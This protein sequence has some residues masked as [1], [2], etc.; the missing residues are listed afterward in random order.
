M[1]D[2]EELQ[3]SL[4]PPPPLSSPSS[5]DASA[6]SYPGGPVSLGWPVP[7]RSSG[8]TVDPLE[9]VELQMG[10]FVLKYFMPLNFH[11]IL[12]ESQ[13][14]Q[15]IVNINRATVLPLAN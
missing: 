5:S 1:A 8:R 3:V 14:H 7:S 2:A 13:L 10:D 6:A 12:Y 9:E 4:P 11:R 15:Y